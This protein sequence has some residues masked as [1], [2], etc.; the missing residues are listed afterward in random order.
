MSTEFIR[1]VTI[2]KNDIYL[3]SKSNNDDLP[4]HSWLCKSL[5]EVYQKEGRLGLDRE[6]IR[7]F[8][9]YA[10]PVGGHESIT[11]YQSALRSERAEKICKHFTAELNAAYALLN[12]EDK[13]H[14]YFEQTEAAKQFR[15][16]ERELLDQKYTAIAKLCEEDAA[17]QAQEPAS[18]DGGI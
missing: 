3:T 4:Y 1:S 18:T 7:M 6:V 17:E 16:T 11:R 2:L 5:S 13:A 14:L 9:E 12:D 15:Q 10:Q 8:C